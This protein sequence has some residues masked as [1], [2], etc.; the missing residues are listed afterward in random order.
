MPSRLLFSSPH[1]SRWPSQCL[2]GM[3]AA[4]NECCLTGRLSG[5]ALP[6]H[7]RATAP[8][9]A[10]QR[11]VVSRTGDMQRRARTERTELSRQVRSRA[12]PRRASISVG[13]PAYR[14]AHACFECCR[15]FKFAP[16]DSALKCPRCGR[17]LYHLGRSFRAPKSGDAEQWEKVRRL[18]AAGFRFFSYRSYDCPKLPDRLRDVDAF[19]A[20]NPRHPFR[21]SP[22]DPGLISRRKSRLT[23]RLSGPA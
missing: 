20:A 15:S 14:I 13:G 3:R 7:D 11:R 17:K 8:A 16:R 10:A 21:V 12:L 1:L 18:V 6:R 23:S 22:S 5:P 4:Q 9:P 2:H 19:I